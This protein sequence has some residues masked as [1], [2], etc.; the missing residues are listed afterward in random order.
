[1]KPNTD[2]GRPTP[3]V[4]S[5]YLLAALALL[6]VAPVALV[7]WVVAT[8]AVRLGA[9]R[10]VVAVCG[11]VPGIVAAVFV[12]PKIGAH[13]AAA[14][15]QVFGAAGT[16]TAPSWALLG[17]VSGWFGRWAILTAPLGV[18][19]GMVA[20]AIP[21]SQ[22]ALPAPEW[23]ARQRRT[24][25]RDQ[26]RTRKRA[27]KRADRE[28]ADLRSNALAVSLGGMVASWRIG[29]LVV[30]P[31]GQLGLAWLLIGA[32]GAGKTTAQYRLGYLAGLERRHLVVIDA[33]GGHDGLAQ[34]MVAAYLAAWPDARVRLF[35][36]ER[37]DIWRGSPQEV[38]NRLVEVW[39]WS[40]ESSYWRESAM[41]ALRLAL[42]QPGPPC[43]SG[44]E[45]VRRLDPA[46]LERAWEHDPEILALVRSMSK[47]KNNEL[48]G[49][50]IRVGNLVAALAGA[51]DG[52]HSWEDADCWV[53]TVPAMVAS[54]DADSALR[55]MLADY[56]HF[57]MARKRRG[58]PS[59][60][61]VDE[62]SAIAGGRRSAIDLLER[63]R[64]ANAGVILA[65]QSTVALG[66]EEERARLL[67]AA[68]AILLFRTPQ[69]AELAA[70]AGTTREAEAAWQVDDQ[71]LTGRSTI[72]MRARARVDQDAVRQLPVGEAD[73]IVRG[74]AERIRIIRTKMPDS[75]Q[76]V[77]RGLT[78]PPIAG[79]LHPSTPGRAVASR[80]VPPPVQ[81]RQPPSPPGGLRP[82]VDPPGRSPVRRY[83]PPGA[84]GEA[85]PPDDHDHQG[86]GEAIE[87]PGV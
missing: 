14:A 34:G 81:S 15:A 54:R 13:V 46:A 76:V 85:A 30:P 26:A 57:T 23:E 35:P 41:T 6:L 32:P 70:L 17:P 16:A 67:A 43:R 42:G 47:G 22:P 68:S 65:G 19:V 84:G 29:D 56:S 11:L 64:G 18:P 20:A 50:H 52:E 33:K 40:A 55:V 39:D 73:L 69:P 21:P 82:E 5:G 37:L 12:A 78:A 24:R 62:F 71:E 44:A 59:L 4:P 86:G 31:E 61:M 80:E 51:L 66:N 10:W 75:T 83:R 49:V 58:Q 38:V 36:Q 53:V 63:G 45:L 1:V 25:E 60:L 9:R 77:A 28:G 27:T 7:A 2:H 74:V 8:A 72:T 48:A 79:T 87:Q 3:A